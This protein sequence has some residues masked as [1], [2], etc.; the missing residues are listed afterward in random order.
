MW[1]KR[2]LQYEQ[3]EELVL[4]DPTIEVFETDA[5]KTKHWGYVRASDGK[6]FGGP[7]PKWLL[8]E[9]IDINFKELWVITDKIIPNHQA[10][11]S[12]KR[13]LVRCDNKAAV[14]YVNRRYGSMMNLEKLAAKID[15]SE[16]AFS[17]LL[18]SV[19]IRGIHNVIAD[20]S[21]RVEGWADEWN[22]HPLRDVSLKDKNYTDIESRIG[23]SFTVD[24]F[25]DEFNAKTPRFQS[26]KQSALF[27]KFT[28]EIVWA[29]P[30]PMI[31][32]AWLELVPETEAILVVTL[33]EANP[34]ILTNKNRKMI[35]KNFK[36]IAAL[37]AKSNIF[38]RTFAD[39]SGKIVTKRGPTSSHPM[40][41]LLW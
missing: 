31:S 36:R 8:N 9:K 41:A 22:K 11:W 24:A 33:F 27:C 38:V 15:D 5:A 1:T 18:A 35:E 14:S 3:I 25:A 29:F 39:E 26:L 6:A 30:P 23:I 2:S 34:A 10:E 28:S 19:H 4:F 40:W 13:I 21:S 12:G 20:Q 37:P 16:L 17:Y 7:W 32:I